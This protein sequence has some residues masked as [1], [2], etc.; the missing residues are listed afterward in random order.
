MSTRIFVYSYWVL[1]RLACLDRDAYTNKCKL[2]YVVLNF[3]KNAVRNDYMGKGLEVT[4][5]SKLQ[6]KM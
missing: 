2:K 4:I 5:M 3:F 6:D 1:D